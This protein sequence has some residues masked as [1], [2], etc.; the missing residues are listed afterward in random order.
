[1]KRNISVIL[2]VVLVCLTLLGC[3]GKQTVSKYHIEYLNKE[4][5]E[6]KLIETFDKCLTP[7]REVRENKLYFCVMARS[8]SD[9]LHL[10]E[11]QG[12]YLDLDKL[13]GENYKRELMEFNLGYSE[14]GYL[15][16]CHRC[17]GM[18]AINYPIPVAEQLDM[19]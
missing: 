2:A 12:D 10:E 4:M 9:N 6:K 17:H 14:K 11:G 1:M 8:V 16:M 13:H 15:D 3:G 5:D 7:C 18:D 19:N